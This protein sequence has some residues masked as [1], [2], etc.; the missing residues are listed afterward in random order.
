MS[1]LQSQRAK[2]FSAAGLVFR[3][4][5][6][7]SW[8]KAT[9]RKAISPCRAW[10]AL[11]CYAVLCL[12]ACLPAWGEAITLPIASAELKQI[13]A[14]EAPTSLDQL[15]RME[16]HQQKLSAQVVNCTVGIVIG[17]SH[18]SGVI[19]SADG[20]V[21]TAAHVAG[22]PNRR[23]SLILPDGSTVSGR[24][25]G[26]Y[27]SLDAGL[28]KI[29]RGGPWPYAEIAKAEE[30]KVGQWCLATGHPGGFEEGRSPVV[31]IG[32]V[33]LKDRFAITTDCTLVGGDSGGP[34]F[35][36]EGRVIGINS[37]IGRFLTTNMHVP[38]AAYLE[39]WDR[40]V[41]GEAWGSLPG[42]GPFLG[43]QGEPDSADA[44][45][46]RILPGGPAEQAG[47]QV[48]DVIVEFNNK[49]ITDFASLQTCVGDCQP[50]ER[51]TII[52]L[53]KRERVQVDLEIGERDR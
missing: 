1:R 9:R 17:S 8:E 53:R 15:R 19:I 3:L 44:V 50:G 23:A 37:R 49:R 38:V 7:I 52:L 48:G 2:H 22:A 32:R 5:R 46:S 28:V 42:R 41:A 6:V 31:R 51:V 27:R 24:S 34:L 39:S 12:S 18:G 35:D 33:L 14:G 21:M 43:V 13:F 29:D 20:Y 16:Q 45:L 26:L 4:A 11:I 25:L 36:M 30:V 40:L 10:T 47:L